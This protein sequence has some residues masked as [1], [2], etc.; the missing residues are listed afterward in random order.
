MDIVDTYIII[1]VINTA[2]FPQ[3][4]INLT[5]SLPLLCFMSMVNK[6]RN[7]LGL[8]LHLCSTSVFGNYHSGSVKTFHDNN[9]TQASA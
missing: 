4:A 8:S 2:R 7:A 3:S 9:R 5:F 6:Y 1:V